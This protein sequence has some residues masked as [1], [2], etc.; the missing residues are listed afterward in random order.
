MHIHM[1]KQERNIITK[2][3]YTA[4]QIGIVAFDSEDIITASDMSDFEAEEM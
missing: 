2:E 4:P 3:K 1:N